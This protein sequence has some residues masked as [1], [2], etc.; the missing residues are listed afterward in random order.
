[1]TPPR[2]EQRRWWLAARH[3]TWVHMEL[4]IDIRHA[5][6]R[7]VLIP[8]GVIDLATIE[9]F[10]AG[11][12]EV[13]SHGSVDLVL[14][15]NEITFI[16]S[17]GLGALFSARRRATAFK[18]SLL[19]ACENDVVLRLFRIT[20]LERVFDVVPRLETAGDTDAPV[21]TTP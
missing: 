18:G 6:D 14:D 19:L 8:R 11:L 3:G 2:L 4:Q 5:G 12:D 13:F 7:T 15:L 1:M 16:D 17:T 21:A 10:R 20:G 9:V